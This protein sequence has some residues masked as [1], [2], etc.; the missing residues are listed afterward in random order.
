MFSNSRIIKIV[1]GDSLAFPLFLNQGTKMQ[2]ERYTLQQGDVLYFA[3]TEP[4]QLFENAIIKK[5]YNADSLKTDEGDIIIRFCP[6]D[7]KLLLP[8]LYFYQ[9]KLA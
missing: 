3:V 4:N 5:T 8:S 7:T 1:R 6:D 9:V 2:P